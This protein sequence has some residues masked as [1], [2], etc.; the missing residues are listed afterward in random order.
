MCNE[1]PIY[2][3]CACGKKGEGTLYTTDNRMIVDERIS[4]ECEVVLPSKWVITQ[5]NIHI[6]ENCRKEVTNADQT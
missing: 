6:C 2:F 4:M 5:S 3:M 1:L